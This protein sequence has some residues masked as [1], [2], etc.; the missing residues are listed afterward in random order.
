[1]FIVQH[2]I[3]QYNTIQYNTVLL[4]IP[5]QAVEY[6]TVQYSTIQ[7][8]SAHTYLFKQYNTGISHLSAS[9]NRTSKSPSSASLDSLSGA[10]S[11]S[12]A[13]PDRTQFVA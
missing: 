10:K 7:S 11:N 3:V 5:I 8:S 12:L 4:Y 2:N 9:P 6:N 13:T 1:M